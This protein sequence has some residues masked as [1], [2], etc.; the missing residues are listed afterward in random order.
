[1][2]IREDSHFG[3]SGLDDAYNYDQVE[4]RRCS[5]SAMA[6]GG[7]GTSLHTCVW[8]VPLCVSM[9]VDVK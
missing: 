3:E 8:L 2:Y 6:Y 7:T 1:M 5:M 9:R 4:G